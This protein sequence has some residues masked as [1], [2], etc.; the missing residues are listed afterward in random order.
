MKQLKTEIIAVGTE[1]LLGQIAN[2][3]GQWLSQQMAQF[4]VNVYSHSVVGD[5]L[6]RVED[7]FTQAHRR[8]D[9]IIVTGGLGPTD[10]DMTREAFQNMTGIAMEEH[11]P[12]M[13]KVENFF[14]RQ[15]SKM[16][17]NNSKQARIFEGST[18]LHNKVGMAPGM[19]VDYEGRTWIFLPGVPKE[20]KQ[21]AKDDVFPHLKNLIGEEVQIK[22][23]VLKFSG[24]GESL[25]EDELHDLIQAQTNPTI[26]SLA[27]NEAVVI[28][29]TARANSEAKADKLLNKK[30]QQILERVGSYYFGA[31]DDTL[32]ARLIALL[33]ERNKRIAAA[34]SLT[35]GKF[36]DKLISVSGASDVVQGGIVCYGRDVK[37]NLLGVSKE[38]I[39]RNGTVSEECASE[40]ASEVWKKCGANIGISFTGAAGP[41]EE[42]GHPAGTV[43]I[44]I[45]Q[46]TGEKNVFSFSFQGD[47]DTVRHL[48][49]LKGLELLF[50]YLKS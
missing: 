12:T 22:S 3:N 9:I 47:R 49:T 39:E 19:I 1:L 34:E 37:Q 2:T 45:A 38:T 5:N 26:A 32:E 50:N 41:K 10:D 16:T 23:L 48:A 27:Q 28:R 43:F 35:G 36:T 6:G 44:A 20:M 24:I 29:L 13:R 7:I 15:G 46:D 30:K 17:P 42:E 8:S 18:V 40:M 14:V 33:K 21:L 4:G 31:D 11:G 25:L